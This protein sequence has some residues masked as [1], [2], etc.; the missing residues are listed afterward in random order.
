MLRL[1]LDNVLLLLYNINVPTKETR[2][3][4]NRLSKVGGISPLLVLRFPLALMKALRKAARE[5]KPKLT[6]SA[7]ARK[8]LEHH[9]SEGRRK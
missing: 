6:P 5:H 8:I 9:L 2:G 4:W 3:G 1:F 7:Y